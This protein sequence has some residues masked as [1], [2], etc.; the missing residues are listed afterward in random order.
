MHIRC[1]STN[2]AR[3]ACKQLAELLRARDVA[4]KGE[5]LM[6]TQE[7]SMNDQAMTPGTNDQAMDPPDHW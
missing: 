6:P 2:V 4:R 1:T 5:L 7:P 3:L